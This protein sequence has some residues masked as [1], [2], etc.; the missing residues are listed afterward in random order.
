[1]KTY[2]IDLHCHTLD[3]S[4]DGAVPAVEI[5]ARLMELGFSGV[6]FTDHCYCWSAGELEEL[7]RAASA[8]GDF[9][10]AS[11]QEVRAFDPETE[12]VLGD[13]LVYGPTE[14]MPDGTPVGEIL[15]RVK[16]TGGFCIGAHLGAPVVGLGGRAGHYPILAAETWNGRY[17]DRIA[18]ISRELAQR[19]SLTEV[20]GSDTHREPDIGGGATLFP[21]IPS[22]LADVRAMI[23]DEACAPWKPSLLKR[24][25]KT[26]A[27]NQEEAQEASQPPP[28]PQPPETPG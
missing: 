8:P 7:R 6:I 23:L 26:L 2:R 16:E 11:G 15:A 19:Y 3:H 10:L 1:M 24:L 12:T 18:K 9:F 4:Y 13:F 21:A 17:G 20:G 28:G 14:P 25:K 27:K 5:V 22:S